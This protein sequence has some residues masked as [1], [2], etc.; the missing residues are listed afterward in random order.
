ME[1][2][3]PVN[4]GQIFFT[5][6]WTKEDSCFTGSLST[7]G[8]QAYKWQPQAQAQML[9]DRSRAAGWARISLR[10]S[11]PPEKW[12]CSTS[13]S[14]PMESLFQQINFHHS[15]LHPLSYHLSPNALGTLLPLPLKQMDGVPCFEGLPKKWFHA[16]FRPNKNLLLEFVWCKFCKWI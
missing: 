4:S 7:H 10:L 2:K 13:S 5:Q 8:S 14:S 12:P 6:V 16:R 15:P 9:M 11:S 3:K 1:S